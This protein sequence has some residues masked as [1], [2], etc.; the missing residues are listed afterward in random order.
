MN[1]IK[2]FIEQISEGKHLDVDEAGRAFQI[3][4]SGGA[5]P[6]QIAAVLMGLKKNG[7]TSEEITGAVRAVRA[8]AI[9]VKAPEN[10]IDTCGTGGDGAGTLNVSTAV[11]LV[12]A[13]CGVPVAK[14]GNRSVSS[15]SGSADVL[16]ELHV[17]IEMKKET[18]EKCLEEAG[19]CFLLA[20]KYHP[21]MRHVGPVRAEL[22]VRTIFNI[23]GPLC[24]PAQTKYQVVGVY[25]EKLLLP[26]A[27]VLKNIGLKTAWVVYGSDGLD[28]ISIA[29]P[30]KVVELKD[31]NIKDFEVYPEE[32]G[33][34]SQPLKEIVGEDAIYNARKIKELLKGNHGAYRDIVLLNSAAAL[35]VSGKAKDLKEGVALA[36]ESIDSKKAA[37]VLE[38]MVEISN[39]ELIEAEADE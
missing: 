38:R 29:A 9:K 16:K 12:V 6:P 21:G 34:A 25:S 36:A 39:S 1:E 30:T 8:K 24:N 14:H 35:V 28:E 22:G 13:G 37:K 32:A 11:A 3:I 27:N 23:L 17:N 2:R 15:R 10:A 20:P 7:E 4:M 5:T 31:G 26:I 19:M 33:L 18:A